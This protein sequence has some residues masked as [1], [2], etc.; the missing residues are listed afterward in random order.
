MNIFW[1]V[2][3]TLITILFLIAVAVGLYFIF[4]RIIPAQTNASILHVIDGDSY[5]VKMDDSIKRVQLIGV[6]APEWHGADIKVPQCLAES[7]PSV[8]V[9]KFFR[10]SNGY[11]LKVR[12][13]RDS[14]IAEKDAHGRDLYYVYLDDGSLL[15]EQI[16]KEGL[17]KVLILPGQDLQKKSSLQSAE[18]FARERGFGIWNPSLCDGTF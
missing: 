3:R 4:I 2:T 13:A 6:D 15:N 16:L 9:D 18:E 14:N 1:L 5:V 7:V 11:N 12:L 8:I 10:D 17:A